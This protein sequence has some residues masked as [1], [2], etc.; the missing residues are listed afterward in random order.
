MP[1]RRRTGDYWTD[2]VL[3]Y[4][5]KCTCQGTFTEYCPV[6]SSMAQYGARPADIARD[7]RI[8]LGSV[9]WHKDEYFSWCHENGVQPDPMLKMNVMTWGPRDYEYAFF[10][11]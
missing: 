3:A 1:R 8:T 10:L 9:A 6:I 2:T 11:K 5:P 7:N 4:V